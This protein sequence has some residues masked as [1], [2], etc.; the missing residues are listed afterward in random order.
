MKEK[1]NNTYFKI[2]FAAF[3][4]IAS[5]ILLY[6]FI[7]RFDNILGSI[8]KIFIILKPLLY[9][10]IIAFLVTQM[11]NFFYVRFVKLFKKKYNK[12]QAEK[13]AKIIS[14]TLSMII[15]F[16]VLFLIFYLLIPKVIISI[17]GVIEAWP[18]NMEN[19]ELWL[20]DILS[21]TP[22]LEES[23]LSAVNESS[24]SILEWLT[25]ALLPTMEK[26]TDGVTN[27]LSDMYTFLKNFIVG[28]VFSIYIV[29]NKDKFIAQL[30]K[31]IYTIFGIKKGNNIMEIG[32]YSYKIFNGFVKGKLLTSLIIGTATY[33]G[34]LILGLPYSLLISIIVAVTNIIPF[35]GPIIG[36]IPSVILVLLSSPLEALYFTILCIILQQIEGN[37]LEPKI[38]GNST[39]ISG[40]WVL[41][42]IIL[43]EGLFGFVGMIIGV[44]IFAIIYHF[45]TLNIN[46]Y[47]SKKEM[48]VDDEEYMNLKYIDETTKKSIKI[49]KKSSN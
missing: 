7:L 35:F 1:L 23:I 32:R 16:L 39:G 31:L 5:S 6:F 42:A 15:L 33:I 38:V 34:M 2:A 20:E 37:I 11:Y 4:V 28:M 25:N 9:G 26:I 44:P 48:P 30:K 24:S 13:E 47:L 21:A 40:F 14:I 22:V 12:E 3:S 29:S 41:F 49:I 43:F 19:I 27:G 10:I 8:G 17:I 45:V 36:W 18:Q 46:R